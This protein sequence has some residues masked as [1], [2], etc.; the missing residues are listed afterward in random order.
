MSILLLKA[1][2]SPKNI[3]QLLDIDIE[4][5]ILHIELI[6]VFVHVVVATFYLIRPLLRTFS[7]GSDSPKGLIFHMDTHFQWLIPNIISHYGQ[8]KHF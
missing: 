2:H 8:V 1:L 6:S 7:R 3:D 5:I 4:H